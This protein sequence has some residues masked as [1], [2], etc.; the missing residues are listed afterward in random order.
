MLFR[1]AG[2]SGV[3]AIAAGALHTVALVATASGVPPSITAQPVGQTVV[4][5]STAT[6][7]VTA[8]GTAPLSYQW[9]YNGTNLLAGATNTVLALANVQTNQAGSY[10]VVVTNA[11]G[12]VTSAPASL[13]SGVNLLVGSWHGGPLGE[14]QSYTVL[15]FQENGEFFLVQDGNPAA[16]PTGQDGMEHGTY[17]WNPS[18]GAFS[19]VVQSDTDGEWG[20]SHAGPLFLS[21]AGNILTLSEVGVEMASRGAADNGLSGRVHFL[22]ADGAHTFAARKRD[23]AGNTGPVASQVWTIDTAPPAAPANGAYQ[24]ATSSTSSTFTFA[25]EIGRAHV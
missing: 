13:L 8:T 3:T 19:P 23:A 4:A 14:G 11:Y 25:G 20:F 7:S 6:F 24:A 12:S 22:L 21:V 9:F 18:T 2:L 16:D 5:G 15:T 10:T 17:T 1:S